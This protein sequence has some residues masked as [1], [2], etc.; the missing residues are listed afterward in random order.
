M[1]AEKV[2]KHSLKPKEGLI[3]Q[4]SRKDDSAS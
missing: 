3:Y 1:I 2:G 4:A